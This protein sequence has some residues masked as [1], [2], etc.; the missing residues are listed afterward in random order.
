M[1]STSLFALFLAIGNI[2]DD[3]IVVAD[4]MYHERKQ[5]VSGVVAAIRGT[6][7]IKNA[8]VF[9]VL[10]SVAAVT[11]LLVISGGIAEALS[12]LPVIIIGMLLISL[13]E[14]LL[15]VPNHLSHIH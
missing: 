14:T 7:G 6:R 11:P 1:R 13:I 8:L 15:A 3:A 10:T 4:H 12:A 5:G 9:A 2:V